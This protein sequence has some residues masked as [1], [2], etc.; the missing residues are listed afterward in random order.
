MKNKQTLS[1]IVSILLVITIVSAGIFESISS[2]DKT[3]TIDKVYRD[4]LLTLTTDKDIKPIISIDC[5]DEQCKYSASQSGIINSHDNVIE[6]KYCSEYNETDNSCITYLTYTIAEI[7]TMVS[8]QVT[9]RLENFANASIERDAIAF[10]KAS[11]G[12]ISVVEKK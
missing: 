12:T 8:E 9:S 7:E 11:E 2:I 4:K 10:E 1:I 6:R 5:N 3:T